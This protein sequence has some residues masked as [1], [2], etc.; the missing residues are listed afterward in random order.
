MHPQKSDTYGGAYFYDKNAACLDFGY[1][2][3]IYFTLI[4]L[5]IKIDL[6][7]FTSAHP[8]GKTGLDPVE[9]NSHVKRRYFKAISRILYS[10]FS[11]FTIQGQKF[12]Q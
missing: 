11:I 1:Y 9:E 3:I 6:M 10:S 4:S 8:Y 5:H 12:R 2:E 7:N